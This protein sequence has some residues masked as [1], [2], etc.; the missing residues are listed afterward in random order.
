MNGRW[1]TSPLRRGWKYGA[2]TARS[3]R[4][5]L[6]CRSRR[7]ISSDPIGAISGRRTSRWRPMPAPSS[8]GGKCLASRCA[9]GRV[10]CQKRSSLARFYSMSRT[11]LLYW[12]GIPTGKFVPAGGVGAQHPSLGSYLTCRNWVRPEPFKYIHFPDVKDLGLEIVP[13]GDDE[14][15]ALSTQ[16]PVKGIV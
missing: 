10:K 3:S 6:R 13:T 9:R 2:P 11:A 4:S 7:S 5:V 8:G 12:G 1:H 16:R 15:V 14:S